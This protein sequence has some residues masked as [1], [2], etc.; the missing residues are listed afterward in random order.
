MD[1]PHEVE[2]VLELV[3]TKITV[4]FEL[5]LGN[6]IEQAI[7]NYVFANVQ[8]TGQVSIRND[9]HS[10]YLRSYQS[11]EKQDSRSDP[12]ECAAISAISYPCQ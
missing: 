6:Q 3:A 8:F 9:H 7:P 1:F 11:L 2:V 12:K 4:L 10:T 5:F